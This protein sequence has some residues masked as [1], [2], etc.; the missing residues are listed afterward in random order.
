M[1]KFTKLAFHIYQLF[2]GNC[3]KLFQTEELDK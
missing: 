3:E 1:N 2:I